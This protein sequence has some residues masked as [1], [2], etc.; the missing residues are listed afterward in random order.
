MLCI[1][2]SSLTR[3][4]AVYSI[5]NAVHLLLFIAKVFQTAKP[6][7]QGMLQL[8]LFACSLLIPNKKMKKKLY[9]AFEMLCTCS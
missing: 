8:P 5:S 9:T 7:I 6:A 1:D 4:R 3:Q 2:I